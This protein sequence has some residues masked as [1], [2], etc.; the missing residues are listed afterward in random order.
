MIGL[1]LPG[2]DSLQIFP[3]LNNPAFYQAQIT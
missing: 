1:T 2:A 3:V